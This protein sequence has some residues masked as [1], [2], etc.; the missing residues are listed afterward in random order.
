MKRHSKRNWPRNSDV[1]ATLSALPP[2]IKTLVI[3]QLSTTKLATQHNSPVQQAPETS[4]KTIA[5]ANAQQ[6]QH[7]TQQ[8]KMY[9]FIS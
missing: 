3:S 6:N 5:N 1:E 9:Q 2:V 8:Q 4:N 7:S